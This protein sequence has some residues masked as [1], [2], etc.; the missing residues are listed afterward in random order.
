MSRSRTTALAAVMTVVF[1]LSA[2]VAYATN[3]NWFS[4][5]LATGLGYAGDS[6]AHSVNYI[7]GTANFNG[8][9]V[10][11]DQGLV[12]YAASSRTPAGTQAC[13]SS[14]GFANRSENST[15]CYRGWIA[16]KNGFDITV[17]P[18]TRWAY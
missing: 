12:G 5:V 11:K 1:A 15:C 9:C 4:G 16:N 7:E 17:D 8:F 13:A 2:S 10:A 3:V 14:G 18:S 6:S